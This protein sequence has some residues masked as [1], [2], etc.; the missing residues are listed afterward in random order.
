MF[1]CLIGSRAGQGY[2]PDWTEESHFWTFGQSVKDFAHQKV[3]LSRLDAKQYLRVT[4]VT[5]H[6][7]PNKPNARAMFDFYAVGA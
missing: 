1:I 2:Y 5:A 4:K 6:S 7:N 3:E